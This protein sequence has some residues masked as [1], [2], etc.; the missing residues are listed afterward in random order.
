MSETSSQTQSAPPMTEQNANAS[1]TEG[2][3]TTTTQ[4]EHG[5]ATAPT[6][7]AQS[8][9]EKAPS[10]L[11]DGEKTEAEKPAGAPEAYTDFTLPEGV[12]LEAESL[13]KAQELFK[14]LNLPQEGAQSLVDFYVSEMQRV[15]EAVTG[16]NN[17]AIEAFAEKGRAEIMADPEIGPKHKEI[18]ANI[19][20]AYD[21]LINAVPEK[22]AERR[23]MVNDFKALMDSTGV[24]NALP[25]VKVLKWFADTVTE[26]GHVRGGNPSP[27]GQAANGA[28]QR[29]TVAQ[30][31]YPNNPT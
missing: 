18:K 6:Q 25:F 9:N 10:F 20:K 14:G 19:G 15:T 3:Q 23:A 22:A 1:A 28:A 7:T 29:P 8:S 2:T 16:R 12:K 27:H 26:P 21:A 4:T 11:N 24:G 30:S 17:E 31:M 13:T 5:S